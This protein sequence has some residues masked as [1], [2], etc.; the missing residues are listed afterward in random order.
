[1]LQSRELLNDCKCCRCNLSTTLIIAQKR[2]AKVIW[3]KTISLTKYICKRNLVDIFYH[4]RQVSA[5][6]TTLVRGCIRESQMGSSMVPFETAMVVSYRLSIMTI[7][8]SPTIRPQ[9]ASE[10][11]RR[12]NQLEVGHF[13]AKF[14]EQGVDRR[15][16]HFNVI[17][18]RQRALVCERSRV[19][20]F[21][22]LSTIHERDIQ[23]DPGTVTS[24]PIGEIAFSDVA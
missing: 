9:F 18:E 23:T 6:V 11:I 22:H 10:Y 13:E 8:L 2:R 20:I 12:L 7:A 21:C 5:R 1:M 3:Q 24:I 16:P 19:D 4:I 14:G 15:K 17:C